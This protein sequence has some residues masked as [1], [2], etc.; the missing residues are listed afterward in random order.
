MS[1][2]IKDYNAVNWNELF[3]Y[4]PVVPTGLR[5]KED[6]LTGRWMKIKVAVKGE[7]AGNIHTDTG[8]NS[9]KSCTVSH[10]GSNWFSARVIWIMHNGHLDNEY[11]IDHIDGNTLNNNLSN[12]RVVRQ[13]LNNRNASMRKDNSTGVCG[14][15]F[16]TAS[17]YKGGVYTYVTATWYDSGGNHNSK[18]F[19][20]KKLGL[21]PAFAEA[22]KFRQE[23]IAKLNE[24]GCGYTDKHGK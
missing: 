10:A 9:Y 2:A 3:V 22:V 19:S 4:D 13:T 23:T 12:L 1:R 11:V 6:R 18:H 8:K 16:T 15:N 24:Q 14:V 17:D 20:V 21:L 7:P 5:W